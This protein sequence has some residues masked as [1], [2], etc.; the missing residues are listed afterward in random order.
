MVISF[1]IC[2]AQNNSGTIV[3]EEKRNLHKTLPEE[4]QMYKSRIPEFRTQNKKLIF[5]NNASLYQRIV[6]EEK[7]ESAN[8]RERG[9]RGRFSRNRNNN[10]VYYA[11]L[12][13]QT[14]T[15]YRE[16]F[17]KSFLIEGERNKIKWKMAPEQK[18]VGDFLCQKATYQDSLQSIEA[19]FTPMIPVSTG[20]AEYC[21]LPGMI[22]YVDINEGERTFTA[23][24][25]EL[26]EISEE[27]MIKPSKGKKMTYEDF[28]KMRIEKE[29][30]MRKEFGNKGGRRWGGRG[31]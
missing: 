4:M 6:D 30:E 3:Y 18:M 22:L 23:Q 13:S 10:N 15:D 2:V 17:G 29:E 19:W 16:F 11:D 7:K 14:S 8:P 28:E 31:R 21:G 26:G 27:E 1:Q 25:I 24:S 9:R 5:D 20:P 12:K